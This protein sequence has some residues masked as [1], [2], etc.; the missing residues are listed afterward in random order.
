LIPTPI[1]PLETPPTPEQIRE[2]DI[3][4]PDEIQF[5]PDDPILPPDEPINQ[6]LPP[7]PAPTPTRRLTRERRPPTW[8]RDYVPTDTIAMPTLFEP[9]LDAMQNLPE[10]PLLALKAVRQ[11]DPNTMYLWQAMKQL[12]WAQFEQAMQEEVNAHTVNVHW[13]LIK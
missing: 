9:A 11:S 13:K 10:N 5:A 1:T 3:Q 8:H 12:D 6:P 7:P 4:T 2:I